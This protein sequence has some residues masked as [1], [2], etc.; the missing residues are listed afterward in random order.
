[1]HGF[2]IFSELKCSA[3]RAMPL[4]H[5]QIE[6][7]IYSKFSRDSNGTEPKIFMNTFWGGAHR[8]FAFANL[9]QVIHRMQKLLN[10]EIVNIGLPI[11]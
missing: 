1:M 3:R 9:H 4:S 2:S 11:F 8:I 6:Y 10:I 7:F 5:K